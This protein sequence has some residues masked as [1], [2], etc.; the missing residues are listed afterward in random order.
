MNSFLPIELVIS[1]VRIIGLSVLS[2]T[3]KQEPFN[4][5]NENIHICNQE[6]VILTR[7]NACND[8][9]T[10]YK[11]FDVITLKSHC[12]I[13]FLTY[14]AENMSLVFI[15]DVVF[16]LLSNFRPETITCEAKLTGVVECLVQ[17]P[18]NTLSVHRIPTPQK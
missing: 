17:N 12:G 6:F 16:I 11:H 18:Q 9:I 3:L 4:S 8:L 2:I 15:S 13:H 5:K 1:E 7:T 14:L 10:G